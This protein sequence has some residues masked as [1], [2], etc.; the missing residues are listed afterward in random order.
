MDDE[1]T[2]R[3]LY[4]DGVQRLDDEKGSITVPGPEPPSLMIMN[5]IASHKTGRTRQTEKDGG[6]YVP[7]PQ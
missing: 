1:E 4:V 3:G 5:R 7:I 2:K 6:K